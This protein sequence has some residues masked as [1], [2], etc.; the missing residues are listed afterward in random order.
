MRLPHRWSA[1][2]CN[3]G[4]RK[5]SSKTQFGW[6]TNSPYTMY[7]PSQNHPLGGAGYCVLMF[8]ASSW[9]TPKLPW[10]ASSPDSKHKKL[11]GAPG[12]AT[13]NTKLL[14]IS[15]S[16]HH[17]TPHSATHSPH[18]SDESRRAD[19]T[20]LRCSGP[21]RTGRRNAMQTNLGTK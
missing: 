6:F 20:S 15:F 10:G 1:S 21:Q 4:T 13:S 11:L 7:L 19:T 2:K 12:I 17:P 9:V 14:G 16:R 5:F 18:I 3:K 8:L